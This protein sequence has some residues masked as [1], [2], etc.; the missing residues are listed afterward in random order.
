M[1]APSSSSS[2]WEFDRATSTVARRKEVETVRDDWEDDDDEPEVASEE[3]NRKI[4]EEA[5]RKAPAPMPL[6]SSASTAPP[7][8]AFQPTM[9]ILKRPQTNSNPSSAPGTPSPVGGLSASVSTE[10]L[11]EREARYQAARNRIFGEN[12]GSDQS[13]TSSTISL[14]LSSSTSREERFR[15]SS[16][17][18]PPATTVTR[19]PRGPEN[20]HG[21]GEKGVTSSRGFEGR[22]AKPQTPQ[23]KDSTS[24]TV[25]S[26]DP[27]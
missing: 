13:N 14:P 15:A 9:K 20:S 19:N 2:D 10:S 1:S 17:K 23:S 8:G 4:W 6:V 16:N 18:S 5:D 12:P 26:E 22:R 21:I 3:V 24:T 27:I 11:Q 7:P 25:D